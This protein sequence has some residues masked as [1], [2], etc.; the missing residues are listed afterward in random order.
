L[1]W[2]DKARLT[3]NYEKNVIDISKP[4]E[5]DVFIR[6]S[7]N[8]QDEKAILMRNDSK[9]DEFVITT[10]YL[11]LSIDAKTTEKKSDFIVNL[12]MN[13]CKEMYLAS[14]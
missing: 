3:P 12:I 5:P 2:I 10:H 4:H 8:E 11:F 1:D 7:I 9:V 14:C 6:L 13:D